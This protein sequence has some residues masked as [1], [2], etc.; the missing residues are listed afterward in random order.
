MLGLLW[1]LGVNLRI[2]LLAVPPVLPQIIRELGLGP[3]DVGALSS[4]PVL[5]LSLAAIGGSLLVARVGA[6]RALIV[7]VLT[8]GV[9]SALRGVGSSVSVLFTM[10]LVMSIGVAMMQPA[11]PAVTRAW[12]AAHAGLATAIYANGLLIGEILSASLTIPLVLPLLGDSWAWSLAFWSLP[13]FLAAAGVAVLTRE[14]AS[15]APEVAPVW[16]PDWRDGVMW[17]AGLVLSGSGSLYFASNGFIPELLTLRGEVSL[18]GPTLTALNAGQLPSS[19]LLALYARQLSARRLPV[20]I[21]GAAGAAGLAGLLL[22]SGWVMV[23]AAALIGAATAYVLIW[24]LGLPAILARRERIPQLSAGI[25]TIGYLLAF[26]SPLVGGA[27]WDLTAVP[28]SSLLPSAFL[29]L[30]CV[31]SVSTLRFDHGPAARREGDSPER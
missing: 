17:R 3:F 12:C 23:S 6:R 16:L 14:E 2:T 22:L 31:I 29:L 8:V 20:V 19:F 10:T 27:L 25:F 9:G 15:T 26:L 7:G 30:V 28:A 21:A 13:A 4:L 24:S 11:M 1:L 18:I 5:L